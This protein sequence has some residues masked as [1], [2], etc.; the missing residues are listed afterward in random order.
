MDGLTQYLKETRQELHHVA[1]PT[2]N[3]TIAYT[4]LVVGICIITAAY[5]GGLDTV[6][7]QGLDYVIENVQ[8]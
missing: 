6:F 3:Q 8:F 4:A 2:R 5:L 7:A 1:W